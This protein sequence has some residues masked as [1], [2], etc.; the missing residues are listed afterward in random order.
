MEEKKKRGRPK[1]DPADQNGKPTRNW[2]FMVYPES[3]PEEWRNIID[4]YHIEWVHSPL[5]SKDLNATQE[6]KK[7]HW[8]IVIH[9]DTDKSYAQVKEISDKCN[10]PRPERVYSMRAMARYLCHLDNPEKHQYPTSEI[11]SFGGFDIENLL[12]PGASERNAIITQMIRY[13]KSAE[14]IELDDLVEYADANDF[15]DWLN[16]LYNSGE[17]IISA[18]IR[19]KRHRKQAQK[20]IKIDIDTGEISE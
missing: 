20:P 17:R 6:E 18:Y 5:H 15:D 3:A 16:V 8:H 10:S 7:E 12:R 13:I 1:K 19:S 14:I 2:T 11:Q 4:G 9:F